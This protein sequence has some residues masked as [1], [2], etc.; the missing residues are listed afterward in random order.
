VFLGDDL[1][2]WLV[3]AIGGAMAAGN[4]AALV[5]PPDRRRDD[6]DLERAPIARSVVFIGLGV[7]ASIWALGSLIEV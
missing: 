3:L 5:R 7:A 1:L 2:A 4:L 6:D